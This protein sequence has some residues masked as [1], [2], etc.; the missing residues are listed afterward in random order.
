M[1]G[2]GPG[3]GQVLF[4]GEED[5]LEMIVRSGVRDGQWGVFHVRFLFSLLVN[6]FQVGST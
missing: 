3:M 5:S 6:H 2:V 1:H 4:E